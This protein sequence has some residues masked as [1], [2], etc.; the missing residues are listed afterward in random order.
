MKIVIIM[1]YIFIVIIVLFV[2][3]ESVTNKPITLL[4]VAEKSNFKSTSTYADVMLFIN[5]LKQQYPAMGVETI[6]QT[7][8][9]R[10]IPLLVLGGDKSKDKLVVYIQ[11]NIH[12]GEVEGKEATLMLARDL[13]RNDTAGLLNRVT[14]LICPILNAD[15]NEKISK[16]NRTN[17]NGPVNGVGARHNGQLLDINRDALK[18]ETPEL[19]GVVKNV[20]NKWDPAISVDCH[21][22]NG[23]FHQEPVTS[24]WMINPNGDRDLMNYMRDEMM[25]AVSQRLENHYGV[26]NCYYGV[27]VDREHHE[28]GWLN[29]A[30]EPRYL[31]NYVG[32]RNRLAILNENY[33]YAD[34][35]TRVNGCYNLLKSIVEYAG[36]NTIQIEKLIT[37]VD[38][39][40]RNRFTDELKVDSFVIEYKGFPTPD[41]MQIRAFQAN[42]EKDAKGRKKYKRSNRKE[43][44][45]VDYI[46]DYYPVK[47]IPVPLAYLITIP[48]EKPLIDN[49]K[50]HGIEMSKLGKDT[51][52]SVE[53]FRI[54]SLKPSFRLN[55]GHY[56]NS[57]FG[58][59][60]TEEHL[61]KADTY[62]VKTNQPLGNLV[63]YLLEPNTDDC[64]LKWNFFDKYLTSQWG[65]KIYPY[66]VYRILK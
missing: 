41:K 22:T 1:R 52:L 10:D 13:L 3:C 44:L 61:F 59:Y 40:M 18:L 43:T 66:P 23:S 8:E 57:V 34:F 53:K 56:Q 16:K 25:P 47:S 31:F 63:C 39:R 14:L 20:L 21:T 26:L 11:A 49:L 50:L 32:V 30:S 19:R 9:G 17:Q 7:I 37:E 55:Q 54:D 62:I 33:V 58:E 12:A 27:F 45:M 60:V 35:K 42:V 36:D 51:V 6:A 15:G 64:L 2:G 65:N 4:T 29:Y 5:T 46:A 38:S 28:K 48:N 24:S